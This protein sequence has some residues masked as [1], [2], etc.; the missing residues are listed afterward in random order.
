[1]SHL[2]IKKYKQATISGAAEASPYHMVQIV[3]ANI[4]GKIAASKGCIGRNEYEQKGTLISACITLIGALQ[5][6]LNMDEGGE[7]SENLFDLYDYC[8]AKLLE[9]NY[10]GSIEL[11]DEVSAIISEI[12][13]GWDA[14]PSDLRTTSNSDKSLDERA[15]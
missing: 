9:A 2:S 5:D 6:S 13:Q 4:I 11:L 7:I 15:S 1:M 12:K 10:K 14:I 8:Q 3:L